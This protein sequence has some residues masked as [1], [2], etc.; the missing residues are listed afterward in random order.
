MSP[1][2]D[3]HG[4]ITWEHG[5]PR[6]IQRVIS[7]F[8]VTYVSGRLK[9]V[10]P[11]VFTAEKI[12]CDKHNNELSHKIDRYGPK[13]LRKLITLIDGKHWHSKR[14]PMNADGELFTRFLLKC[15]IAEYIYRYK[16]SEIEP[17]VFEWLRGTT[18]FGQKFGLY[19]LN[20]SSEPFDDKDSI[21]A[22]RGWQQLA[23][24]DGFHVNI[25]GLRFFLSCVPLS[26]SESDSLNIFKPG[27]ITSDDYAG[28]RQMH[29]AW[30]NGVATKNYTIKRNERNSPYVFNID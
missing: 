9:K 19:I 7:K 8:P 15:Y 17:I 28:Q 24:L 3:C 20:K 16:I 11:D 12:L 27:L 10:N 6:G 25:W 22:N 14:Q 4:P 30:P 26:N 13:I 23:L 5:I 2:G 1:L 18:E 21:A 29:F